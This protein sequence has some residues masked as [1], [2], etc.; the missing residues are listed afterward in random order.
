MKSISPKV[1]ESTETT[2][3]NWMD[4]SLDQVIQLGKQGTSLVSQFL[5]STGRLAACSCMSSSTNPCKQ[6]GDP[7][8][9]VGWESWSGDEC[10]DGQ[11]YMLVT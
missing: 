3:N 6:F 1:P 2:E 10:G 8:D 11:C 4:P 5:L 7:D 9:C